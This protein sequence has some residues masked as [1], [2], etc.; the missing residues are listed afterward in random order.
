MQKLPNTD[1]VTPKNLAVINQSPLILMD[2]I[3]FHRHYGST[4]RNPHNINKFTAFMIDI[5]LTADLNAV[6]FY[7]DNKIL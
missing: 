6:E 3:R 7:T 2:V 1:V 4:D 5:C